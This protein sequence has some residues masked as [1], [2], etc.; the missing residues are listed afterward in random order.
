MKDIVLEIP[1]EVVEVARLARNE[2]EKEFRKELA[3]RYTRV[4]Y[5]PWQGAHLGADA[6]WE[7]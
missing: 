5:V 4:G 1:A 2:V 6:P 3:L 7:F